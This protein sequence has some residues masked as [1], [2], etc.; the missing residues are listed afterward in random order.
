MFVVDLEFIIMFVRDRDQSD[1][2]GSL[3]RQQLQ[4]E[5]D[6][7]IYGTLLYEDI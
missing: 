6:L 1:G 5:F 2:T 7:R 3:L 4:G